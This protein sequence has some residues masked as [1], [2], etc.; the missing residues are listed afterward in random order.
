VINLRIT[1]EQFNECYPD[2]V[3][4]Y[5]FFDQP[6]PAGISDEDFERR[7]LTN[8]LWRLN[9][10]YHV[11]NKDGD[12]V[13][14]RMNLAQHKVYGATRRHP[15]VII[16]KSRQQGISTFWLVSYFD[17]AVFQP[18]LN[19]GMMAQGVDEAS[20]LLERSKFLWDTLDDS[21][22]AFINVRLDKDNSK[23]FTFS[24]GSQIFI[25]VS[26]RST[27]LQRLHVSEMGKIAN[28]YPIRA[29][30]VKTG[31]LQALGRGNTG[32][33]ESTAEGMNMFKEMWDAAEVALAAGT[34][35]AK[36]FY[37]VFLSWLDDPDCWE[38]V[39]QVEDFEAKKYL[40][41]LEAKLSEEL[42]RPFKLARQ[43]RNFWVVQRREL[44]GDVFQEYP[45]TAE[46]A[47]TA[48]RDGTYW[49]NMFKEHVVAKK[50][51][52]PGLYDPNLPVDVYIDI[53]VSDYGVLVFKQWYRGEYRI[54]DEYWNQGYDMAHYMDEA[55]SRGYNVRC[56]KF[57]HDI[58][59]R[60]YAGGNTGR[61]G[62]ARTR[63]DIANEKIANEGWSC[64]VE[65]VEKASIADGIEAV[66]RIIP[67]LVIDPQ[68][69]YLIKCFQRYTKEWD[70]RL[71][72]WKKTERHDE[73][74]HGAAAMRY[75]AVDSLESASYDGGEHSGRRRRG[76]G[77]TV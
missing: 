16:L 7:Y 75:M 8:K 54:I 32:V 33:I 57:P 18:F 77:Y 69:E 28:N 29:K 64:Y 58:T 49:N 44:A 50:R 40:D 20:T 2:L 48:S 65:A 45:A 31:T 63:E 3:G 30:E 24:N 1:E 73:W 56:F 59:V 19:I 14:F 15:R 9:N 61:G 10:C 22:K 11:I 55:M 35:S 25:R 47:F 4:H 34:M 13:L 43:Q 26:F 74:S 62:R 53:G 6:P 42:G 12:P 67:N 66:R 60:E 27:T 71:Q 41:E 72:A 76:R 39:D 23:E 17:D 70:E 36:D 37:P 21:V 51:V 46:E 68:C 38:E 52:R 5:D